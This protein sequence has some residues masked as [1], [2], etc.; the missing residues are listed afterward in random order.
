MRQAWF[1]SVPL[2]PHLPIFATQNQS[3]GFV[4]E[5]SLHRA[6]QVA[7][8]VKNPA[9]HQVRL[10]SPGGSDGKESACSWEEQPGGPQSV[11]TQ[12]VG[13]SQ[14]ALAPENDSSERSDSF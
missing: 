3:F 6:S 10:G 11:G 7:L 1:L 9:E 2:S 13:H 5:V 12:R 14:S 4:M 8:V